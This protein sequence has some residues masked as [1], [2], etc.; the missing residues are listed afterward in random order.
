MNLEYDLEESF[1][2][3][4]NPNLPSTLAYSTEFFGE[5]VDYE[6]LSG[7]IGHEMLDTKDVVVWSLEGLGY[8]NDAPIVYADG[9]INDQ[10][11]PPDY[12]AY[13]PLAYSPLADSWEEGL[14]EIEDFDWS[15]GKEGEQ[16][17][18]T[19]DSEVHDEEGF[20][21][22]A[23]TLCPIGQDKD[24]DLFN[25]DAAHVRERT[26]LSNDRPEDRAFDSEDLPLV[27]DIA[28]VTE[29]TETVVSLPPAEHVEL[30][31]RIDDG[32][33]AAAQDYM[34]IDGVS[35]AAAARC[36]DISSK[37][38][39]GM[40]TDQGTVMMPEP[41]AYQEKHFAGGIAAEAEP[42]ASLN[43]N[44]GVKASSVLH[45]P[46]SPYHGIHTVHESDLVIPAQTAKAPDVP[47]RDT[48]IS[49]APEIGSEHTTVS[50]AT[51]SAL[52]DGYSTGSPVSPEVLSRR[53][54][55]VDGPRETQLQDAADNISPVGLAELLPS[56]YR[57]HNVHSVKPSPEII[58][59]E[60]STR[61]SLQ[62]KAPLPAQQSKER[63]SLPPLPFASQHDA[64]GDEGLGPITAEA[65]TSKQNTSATQLAQRPS[66]LLSPSKVELPDARAEDQVVISDLEGSK[67][68]DWIPENGLVEGSS[69]IG[70][71][72]RAKDT[73]SP[74]PS[75][76]PLG[77]PTPTPAPEG[78][79]I[80]K[81]SKSSNTTKNASE[82]DSDAPP[83]KKARRGTPAE[84]R[85]SAVK[86][87]SKVFEELEFKPP[88]S[89]AKTRRGAV[90]AEK[91]IT[92]MD[93]ADEESQSMILSSD[94]EIRCSDHEGNDADMEGHYSD[95]EVPVTLS[96]YVP[97]VEEV[98]SISKSRQNVSHRELQ[99]LSSTQYRDRPSNA[100]R[101]MI[102]ISRQLFKLDTLGKLRP[103]ANAFEQS[104]AV[105]GNDHDSFVSVEGS[106][107]T[108]S[109]LKMDKPPM[110]E[111][112]ATPELM[113]KQENSKALVMVVMEGPDARPARRQENEPMEDEEEEE[114]L[115]PASKI[116][117][118]KPSPLPVLTTPLRG[119]FTNARRVTRTRNVDQNGDV[120]PAAEDN[121]DIDNSGSRDDDSSSGISEPGDV[122]DLSEEQSIPFEDAQETIE[123]PYKDDEA[124]EDYSD[125]SAP[126]SKKPKLERKSSMLGNQSLSR[127][128]SRKDT[129]ASSVASPKAAPATNRYGFK[130]SPKVPRAPRTRAGCKAAVSSAAPT[131]LVS[132]PV[133]AS[134]AR[135][136]AKRKAK[137]ASSATA[138]KVQKE[139]EE[140]QSVSVPL[141]VKAPAK[142]EGKNKESFATAES[143]ELAPVRR[144]RRVSAIQDQLK[145]AREQK[146]KALEENVRADV[147]AKLR[148]K[149]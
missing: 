110:A 36:G 104:P 102:P 133:P 126:I 117:T 82:T 89:F 32:Q 71:Q 53:E 114:G 98:P 9:R 99:G 86:E 145:T 138:T 140:R 127:T 112:K 14:R 137:T 25:G 146:G 21:S 113:E 55:N 17:P 68:A 50:Q 6:V 37:I 143:T 123:T 80:C 35:I 118:A 65:S 115:F 84:P 149:V 60:V 67:T 57:D 27:N 30:D 29:V 66:N 10:A 20:D 16:K 7:K 136:P 129:P 141:K 39:G 41:A 19:S 72:D 106:G 135:V 91:E 128:N 48:P 40:T 18:G 79:T 64:L 4:N 76:L 134:K 69:S 85:P 120:K 58:S 56:E 94:T 83:R 26:H 125:T 54:E 59:D 61:H 12:Y 44:D 121:P 90:N 15:N 101:D 52:N 74:L 8:T 124:D 73:Y 43:H 42:C 107:A 49:D 93:K 88:P 24:R 116:D 70:D 139:E 130:P 119:L 95:V 103:R 105:C 147:K 62:L 47:K 92:F 1:A 2:A 63:A 122:E 22:I 148:R 5:L 38:E 78:R 46:A 34:D 131:P 108:V 142:N 100:K 33:H 3:F 51:P 11:H 81:R 28:P 77:S 109:T 13:S 87:R 45:S 96:K 132:K 144:T 75:T 23:G 97:P 111:P 31:S